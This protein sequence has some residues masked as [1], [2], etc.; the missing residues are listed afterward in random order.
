M[1]RTEAPDPTPGPCTSPR[2]SKRPAWLK[3]VAGGAPLTNVTGTGM[4]DGS[5]LCLPTNHR[6]SCQETG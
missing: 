2:P 1:Y 6:A 5:E 4:R 3:V